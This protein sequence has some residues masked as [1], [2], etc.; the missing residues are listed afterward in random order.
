MTDLPISDAARR[1]FN[2]VVTFVIAG[3]V[4][5]TA[6]RY[7]RARR[8]WWDEVRPIAAHRDALRR[9]MHRSRNRREFV[10]QL[11]EQVGRSGR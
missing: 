9:R 4:A 6:Y 2:A 7:E 10:A 5:A 11:I 8:R 3:T 1:R